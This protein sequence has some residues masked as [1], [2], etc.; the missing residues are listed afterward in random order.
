[1]KASTTRKFWYLGNRRLASG[2]VVIIVNWGGQLALEDTSS[3]GIR[4]LGGEVHCLIRGG[5]KSS[6]FETGSEEFHG[7]ADEDPTCSS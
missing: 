7:T 3:D 4:Y 5:K 1:M 2:A 6:S